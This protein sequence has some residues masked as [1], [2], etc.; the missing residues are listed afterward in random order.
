MH[1]WAVSVGVSGPGAPQ[2]RCPVWL[3]LLCRQQTQRPSFEH[4]H[5][6]Q[7]NTLHIWFPNARLQLIPGRVPLLT[8]V[9]S[10]STD[11]AV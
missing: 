11:G 1:V 10:G 7:I 8:K 4:H 6:S 3:S 9:Q 2:E 5:T